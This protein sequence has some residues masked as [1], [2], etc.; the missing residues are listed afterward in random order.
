MALLQI[1]KI[2]FMVFHRVRLILKDQELTWSFAYDTPIKQLF[3]LEPLIYRDIH[4]LRRGIAY[5]IS[6]N[7]G[8]Q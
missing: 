4:I 7:L 8:Y 5:Q 3:I 2:I 6:L 1:V